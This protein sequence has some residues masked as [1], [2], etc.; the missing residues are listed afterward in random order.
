MCVLVR[1]VGG[2]RIEGVGDGDDA[3]QEWDLISL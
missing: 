3:R 1:T 2:E